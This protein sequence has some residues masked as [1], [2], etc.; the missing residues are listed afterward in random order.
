MPIAKKDNTADVLAK[1]KEIEAAL[2]AQG[3]AVHLD[4]RDNYNAGYKFNHWELRG[5]PVRLELGPKDLTQNQVRMVYR[6]NGAK[7]DVAIPDLLNNM[8][9]YLDEIHDDMYRTAKERRDARTA[10]VGDW[11]GFMSEL[12][13]KNI[14]LAPWCDVKQCEVD[15]KKRS[16]ADS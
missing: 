2:K 6:Y 7:Q 1:L 13:K 10:R 15:V 3:I 4:D 8:K 14:I 16:A 11:A 5:V 12:N 9:G